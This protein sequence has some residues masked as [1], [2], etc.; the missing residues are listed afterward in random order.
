MTAPLY[1]IAPLALSPEDDRRIAAIRQAHDPQVRLVAP[2]FTLVFGARA[3]GPETAKAHVA[4]VAARTAPIAWR[5]DRLVAAGDHLFLMPAEGEAELRALHR[6]LYAGPFAGD[7][8]TDIAFEPHVTVGV[9]PTPSQ[10]MAL[11]T[12]IGRAPIDIA[13]RLDRL[14]L[15]AFDGARIEPLGD[16]PFSGAGPPD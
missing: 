5:L 7:L 11:A 3:A 1:V 6:A 13:G 8:R 15:V 14:H 9:L 16:W 2:H 10:A 12:N 4:A